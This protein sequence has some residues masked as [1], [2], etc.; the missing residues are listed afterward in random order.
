M[1]YHHCLPKTANNPQFL[2]D[3][4]FYFIREKEREREYRE[5]KRESKLKR[6]SERETEREGK[7]TW[8]VNDF[9]PT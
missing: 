3:F 6:E 4:H 1:L 2:R 9:G 7:L 8:F 5:E